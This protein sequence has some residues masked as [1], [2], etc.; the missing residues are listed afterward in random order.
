MDMVLRL[1]ARDG[2]VESGGGVDQCAQ[3]AMVGTIKHHDVMASSE[4]TGESASNIR[5]CELNYVAFS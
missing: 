3:V 2:L 1:V 5:K 4:A